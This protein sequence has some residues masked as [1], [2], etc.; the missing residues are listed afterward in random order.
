MNEASLQN[1][2]YM[3]LYNFIESVSRVPVSYVRSERY[4]IRSTLLGQKPE[5]RVS[6]IGGFV[7][8]FYFF[9]KEVGL[10]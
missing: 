4:R 2:A 1:L 10:V 8:G 3:V 9:R 6:I 7:A 5:G